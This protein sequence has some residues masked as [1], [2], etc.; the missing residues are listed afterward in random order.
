ME[1]CARGWHRQRVDRS[2]VFVRFGARL[3]DAAGTLVCRVGPKPQDKA[4]VTIWSYEDHG[5]P[6]LCDACG[7]PIDG[8]ER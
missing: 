7:H 6:W 3:G 8:A 5:R 2:W 4:C 1:T